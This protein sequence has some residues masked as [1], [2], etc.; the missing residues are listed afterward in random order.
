MAHIYRS[1]IADQSQTT[2]IGPISLTGIPPQINVQTPSSVMN[3]GD[4]A[5]FMIVNQ[6]INEWEEGLYTYTAINQLSRTQILDSTNSAHP[7]NFSPGIK[8]VFITIPSIVAQEAD[9]ISTAVSGGVMVVKA[10]STTPASST[11]AGTPGQ[12]VRD[13]TSVYICYDVNMWVKLAGTF[14]F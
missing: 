9:Q 4:T 5:Y 13:A 10:A 1:R 11:A 2:G 3:F 14:T 12:V 7:V 6:G 8:D